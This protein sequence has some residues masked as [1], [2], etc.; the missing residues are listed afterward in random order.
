MVSAHRRVGLLMVTVVTL[1][2]LTSAPACRT[3]GSDTR[4]A[5]L[6]LRA[7]LTP[8]TGARQS[9]SFTVKETG[10]HDVSL[11]FPWPIEDKEAA[12][13]VHRAVGTVGTAAAVPEEFDFSWEILE[14][15]KEVA[16]GSG[17]KGV[18]AVTDSADSGLAPAPNSRALVFGTFP[19]QAGVAYILRVV[20]RSGFLPLLSAKPAFVIE[21]KPST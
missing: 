20:P 2:T 7:R 16:Q 9:W 3:S 18:L 17:Q 6:S 4:E 21:R 19:A 13:L 8:A 5:R 14:G 15:T 1:A 10:V 11:E 12:D